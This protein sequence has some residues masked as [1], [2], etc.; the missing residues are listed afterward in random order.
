MICT[1][2]QIDMIPFN[3]KILH[4]VELLQSNNFISHRKSSS[5]TNIN[6]CSTDKLLTLVIEHCSIVKKLIMQCMYVA[7]YFI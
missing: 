6:R 3:I 5:W 2:A 4:R 1:L 7:K